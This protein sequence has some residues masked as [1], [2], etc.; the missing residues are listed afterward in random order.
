MTVD[1]IATLS[2]DSSDWANAKKIPNE[3]NETLFENLD[4]LSP[5]D[6]GKDTSAE[7]NT[8]EIP[9][10]EIKLDTGKVNVY[11]IILS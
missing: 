10:T 1:T 7:T 2:E 5:E 3:A 6:L 8:D 4:V 9:K 11:Y